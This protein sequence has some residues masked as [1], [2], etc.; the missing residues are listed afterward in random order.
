MNRAFLSFCLDNRFDNHGKPEKQIFE[1]QVQEMPQRADSVQQ[2]SHGGQV[3]RLRIR[4]GAADGRAC[5]YPD[6]SRRSHGLTSKLR[7]YGSIS[8]TLFNSPA[9][10]LTSSFVALFFI[11]LKIGLILP[12]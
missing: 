9:S 2:G 3:P 8:G 12:S 4:S 1:S 11:F 10:S 5:R 6:E 7:L